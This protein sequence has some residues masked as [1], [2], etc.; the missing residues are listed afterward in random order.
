MQA[1]FA[2][3][4]GTTPQERHLGRVQTDIKPGEKIQP[5]HSF[6]QGQSKAE[7]G[8]SL[9][10]L[11]HEVIWPIKYMQAPGGLLYNVKVFT[12]VYLAIVA[13][14][15]KINAALITIQRCKLLFQE[16][17]KPLWSV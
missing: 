12:T 1:L 14:K 2:L 8:S 11:Q 13:T 3:G 4:A 17:Y 10:G 5:P 9:S 7:S 6:D 15:D 16:Y